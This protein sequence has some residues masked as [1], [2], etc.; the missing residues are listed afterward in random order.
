MLFRR[1]YNNNEPPIREIEHTDDTLCGE[2]I[3]NM[4]KEE[5]P[6]KKSWFLRWI[7]RLDFKRV[8]R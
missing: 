6:L 7:T 8:K 1:S 2:K 3:V 5:K 4:V